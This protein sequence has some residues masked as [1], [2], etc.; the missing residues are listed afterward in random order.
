MLA[1]HADLKATLESPQPSQLL[2]YKQATPVSS[3][4]SILAQVLILMTFKSCK[5]NTYKKGER[6]GAEF[7]PWSSE[8]QA[9]G[10]CPLTVDF[11]AAGT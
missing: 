11:V 10:E 6:G 5:M 2:S 3:L 1:R 8:I 4:E 7:R 9:I